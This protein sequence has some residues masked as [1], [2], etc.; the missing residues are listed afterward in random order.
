MALTQNQKRILRNANS[1]L[2]TI[3]DKAAVTEPSLYYAPAVQDALDALEGRTRFVA[4]D[5]KAAKSF[6]RKKT[7]TVKGARKWAAQ[8]GL[9]PLPPANPDAMTETEKREIDTAN[10][11]L[12]AMR[13][14]GDTIPERYQEIDRFRKDTRQL[15]HEFLQDPRTVK[16][17]RKVYQQ[18]PAKL[19][20]KVKQLSDAYRNKLQGDTYYDARKSGEIDE[21]VEFDTFTR[22]TTPPQFTGADLER[23][24]KA[25]A[26]KM[27][28]EIL[29][30]TGDGAE[31][32]GD[33]WRIIEGL[34]FK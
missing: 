30:M 1:R 2:S 13:K 14:R 22:S 21:D 29:T 32:Y 7:S 18:L 33:Y 25:N 26:P 27:Y 28:D 6:L 4:G 31:N 8:Q 24:V 23:W 9:Q 34:T 5:L 11:R 20:Q 12:E 19:G 16:K 15:A 17:P 3:L 10:K